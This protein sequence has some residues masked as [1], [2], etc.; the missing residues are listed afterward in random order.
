MGR[1]LL[2][3]S[4]ISVLSAFKQERLSTKIEPAEL[5]ALSLST[6]VGGVARYRLD[7]EAKFG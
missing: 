1:F 2:K 6:L 5:K 7:S 4:S 3:K